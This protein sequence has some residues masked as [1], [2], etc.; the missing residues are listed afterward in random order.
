[1]WHGP[2]PFFNFLFI[3]DVWVRYIVHDHEKQF[4][5]GGYTRWERLNLE[6]VKGIGDHEV[7]P[8]EGNCL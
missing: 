8:T 1:M 3:L 6:S 2:N 7:W 5:L 4:C